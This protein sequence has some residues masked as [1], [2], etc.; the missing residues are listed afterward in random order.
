MV[1]VL[2]Y[3]TQFTALNVSKPDFSIRPDGSAKDGELF[4]ANGKIYAFSK[5]WGGKNWHRVPGAM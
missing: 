1:Y 5:M 4:H 2:R 3:E